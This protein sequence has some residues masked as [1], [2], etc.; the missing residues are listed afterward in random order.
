MHL[1]IKVNKWMRFKARVYRFFHRKECFNCVYLKVRDCRPRA[2]CYEMFCKRRYGLVHYVSR[3]MIYD[4][5]YM[6]RSWS[7]DCTDFWKK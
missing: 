2:V 4:K 3:V 7:K 6:L 1:D 5:R